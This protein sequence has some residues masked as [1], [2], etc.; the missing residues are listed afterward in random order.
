[1][2]K[3]IKATLW[4]PTQ[5][6]WHQQATLS[7]LLGLKSENIRVIFRRGA[8]CYGIN[9]ADIPGHLRCCPALPR[10]VGKPVRVQLDAARRD[11]LGKLWLCSLSWMSVLRSTPKAISQRG[12]MRHGLRIFWETVPADN[13]PGNV[14][15]GMLVRDSIPKSSSPEVLRPSPP[16]S[17]TAATAFRPIARHRL[18][19][20]P[21]VRESLE[22]LNA[23]FCITCNRRS[24]QVRYARR[25]A[26]KTPSRTSASSMS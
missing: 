21:K 6:V 24:G 3:P 26:C 14:I 8:G 5:G 12:T 13:Y 9:G 19:A 17:A 2:C 18:A 15:T 16:H 22:F 20:L 11:G 23:S 10:S 25:S 4:S 7:M 1:M